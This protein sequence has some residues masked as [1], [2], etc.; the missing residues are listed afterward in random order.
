[1]DEYVGCFE[2]VCDVMG[3]VGVDCLLVG[4]LMDL[5]YLIGLE[6]C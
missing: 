6:L 1:M 2:C 3:W 4:L 5:V